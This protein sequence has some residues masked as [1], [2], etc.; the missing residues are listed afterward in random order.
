M[1]ERKRIQVRVETP[2]DI[3]EV[4]QLEAGRRELFRKAV[5]AIMESEGLGW[6]DAKYKLQ[7]ELKALR[8]KR[9]FKSVG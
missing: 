4:I 3:D 5:E 7:Q 9:L 8:F 1:G 2:V 6:D